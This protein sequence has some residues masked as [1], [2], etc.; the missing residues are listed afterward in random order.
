MLMSLVLSSDI[1]VS[2]KSSALTAETTHIKISS[3]KRI[4]LKIITPPMS[5]KLNYGGNNI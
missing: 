2:F 5:Y 4:F 1:T 3:I